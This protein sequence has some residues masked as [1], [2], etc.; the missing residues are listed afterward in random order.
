M[1]TNKE[2]NKLMWSEERSAAWIAALALLGHPNVIGGS[3]AISACG[4]AAKWKQ[5]LAACLH[6]ARNGEVN[7]KLFVHIEKHRMKF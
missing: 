5:S 6:C 3:A 7:S 2:P 4:R 1:E